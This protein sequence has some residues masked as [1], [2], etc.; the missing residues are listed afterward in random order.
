MINCGLSISRKPKNVIPRDVVQNEKIMVG[1]TFLF[2]IM[3]S[4]QECLPY[5]QM[6]F[7]DN[8]QIAGFKLEHGKR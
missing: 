4:R 2:V 6:N 8:L 5:H 1:Q 3:D 7:L